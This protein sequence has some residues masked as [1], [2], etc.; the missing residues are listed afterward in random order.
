MKK[1]KS[2]FEKRK[3]KVPI[4]LDEDDFSIL[5]YLDESNHSN[6]PPFPEVTKLTN[7]ID[8]NEIKTFM[9]FSHNSLIT[10]KNRLK[11]LGFIN[12]IRKNGEEY[13]YKLMA[14]TPQ[15]KTFFKCLKENMS[16]ELYNSLTVFEFTKFGKSNA[17]KNY[18][19]KI[20]KEVEGK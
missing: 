15:G 17:Y 13:K 19:K 12:E 16:K 5:S 7:V 18:K 1:E 4:L 20:T 2:S 10:H 6:V 9:N 11:K 14:L 8:L 3:A